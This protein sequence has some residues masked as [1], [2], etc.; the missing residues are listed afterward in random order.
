MDWT[1]SPSRGDPRHIPASLRLSQE[2]RGHGARPAPRPHR[3]ADAQTPGC[4]NASRKISGLTRSVLSMSTEWG[5]L[6]TGPASELA[7]DQKCCSDLLNRSGHLIPSTKEQSAGGASS[8][9]GPEELEQ[10]GVIFLSSPCRGVTVY[11]QNR[12]ETT[13]RPEFPSVP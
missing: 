2:S 7:L 9:V 6:P 12:R 5:H 1:G 3:P 11:L 13:P 4:W 10:R 8:L